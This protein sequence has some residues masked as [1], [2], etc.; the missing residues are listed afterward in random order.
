MRVLGAVLAGGLSRRFGSDKALAMWRDEPLIAH[1]IAA[2]K[3]H[4]ENVVVCGREWDGCESLADLP[5]TGLGPL[6]GLCAALAAAKLR[7][8]DAVLSAP[9]DALDL[10]DDLCARLMPAPSVALGQPVIG[11]WPASMATTLLAR[12]AAGGN[13]SMRGWMADYEVREV[14]CGPIRN[15]NRPEDL[16]G[17][18]AF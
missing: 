2:L 14:D 13:R 6:G 5:A 8:F 11:L 9:C 7:G 12:L 1:V 17:L 16:T 15:I 18:T 4:C 10:P 3:P